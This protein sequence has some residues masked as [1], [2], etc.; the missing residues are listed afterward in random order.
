MSVGTTLRWVQITSGRGPAECELAV[1]HVLECFL[2][3]ALQVSLKV[4][5]LEKVR[6]EKDDIYQSVLLSIIGDSLSPFL[7]RW[8]GTLQW[9]CESPY[10]RTHKR[11]NWF[12]GVNILEALES[13]K[14]INAA[15]LRFETMRA[16][17]AGG[18]HVNT[19]D[20]AVRLIHVPTGL[21]AFAQEERSQHMNKK[22]AIARL[23]IA[24]DERSAS[25]RSE[26]NQEKRNKHYELE[27]GNPIRV[28][29]GKDFK[30]KVR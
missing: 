1:S 27:R 17:G 25:A 3:E 23:V 22:L 21:T 29:V 15:D 5:V 20:S 7:K 24:F 9:I 19:T 13:H 11:K 12:V 8:Q 28:F 14:D 26:K 18:Q 10:R 4:E 2:K 6:G 16:S 30:E